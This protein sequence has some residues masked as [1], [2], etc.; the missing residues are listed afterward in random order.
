MSLSG[1][2]TPPKVL[3]FGCNRG[4][5]V[6]SVLSA[7][8]RLYTSSHIRS[9]PILLAGI[10][11]AILVVEDEPYVRML[12][13]VLLERHGYQVL[14]APNGVEAVRVWQRHKE[15][16]HLLL[17]DIVMPEGMSGRE[18]ALRLRERNPA[19]RVIF[20]SGYSPEIAGRELTLQ[21][22]QNFIQKPCPP[23]E[24]LEAV[25]LSLDR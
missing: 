19:L 23:F 15:P 13:R 2:G 17:T 11:Q 12:T 10:C 9:R 22:G 3:G 7:P 8:K 4:L 14:E 24:L 25:R 5:N 16:I 6:W 18:L 20:T 21:P 1:S